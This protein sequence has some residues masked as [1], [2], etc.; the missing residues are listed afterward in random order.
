MP[1]QVVVDTGSEE[2]TRAFGEELGAAAEPGDIVLLRGKLGAG[3][4]TLVQGVARGLGIEDA[5]T[6]PTFVIASEYRGRI[7]LYHVDLYRVDHMDSVTF[8][9][10]AEYFGSDGLCVVEWPGSVPPELVH[11]ATTIDFAVTGESLRRLTAHTPHLRW[12]GV[13]ERWAAAAPKTGPS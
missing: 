2:E 8:E 12:R 10:V 11:E 1:D 4:T 6:S 9:A 5:V 7:P 3:K 13:F